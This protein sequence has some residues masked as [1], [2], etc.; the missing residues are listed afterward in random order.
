LIEAVIL[1]TEGGLKES[2]LPW[3]A[4]DSNAVTLAPDTAFKHILDVQSF[5]NVACV[6]ALPFE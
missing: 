3:S 6:R 4:R 2:R 1:G 5:A